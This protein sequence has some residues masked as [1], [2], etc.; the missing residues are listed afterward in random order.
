MSKRFQSQQQIEEFLLEP[1]LAMLMYRGT[2]PAP[3]GVPVWFDWNGKQVQ[4]FSG[5][6]SPKVQQLKDD[7]NIS[8]LVTNRVG[9]PEGWVSF[10][11]KVEIG[12]FTVN[13]WSALLDR[14]APRYWDLADSTYAKQ[15]EA[16]R[17]VP[18]AF[19]SMNFVPVSIRSGA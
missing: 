7:P 10:D 4:M 11:G 12:D 19:V 15:I 13:N 18:K 3:T 9:E 2:R 16:W 6:T 1:R 8:V 14:V 17:S 5:R